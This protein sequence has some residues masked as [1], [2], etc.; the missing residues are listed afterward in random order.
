MR[1]SADEELAYASRNATQ[2]ASCSAP[3][4]AQYLGN[5]ADHWR[6]HTSHR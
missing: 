1:R 5:H 4:E 3:N 6:M 2:R